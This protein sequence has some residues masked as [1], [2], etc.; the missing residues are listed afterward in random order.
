[1]INVNHIEKGNYVNGPGKRFVLWVQGCSLGCRGCWNPDTWNAEPRLLINEDELFRMI[2]EEEGIEGV[3]FTGGEP[4]HQ[5]AALSTLAARIKTETHLG[6]QVFTGFE[7]EE[8]SS[9]DQ[10]SLLGYV[11][12]LVA[13]RFDSSKPNNNQKVLNLKG[14]Y[15]NW[16]YNN[17]EVEV[18]LHENG[19]IRLTGYP[20]DVFISAL[21]REL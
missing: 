4:F 9:S 6:L 15:L 17:G 14:A 5:A 10:I 2:S 13:G 12:I 16:E 8:L 21:I 1:M 11:D 20:S 3:T 19:D 18:D 7:P